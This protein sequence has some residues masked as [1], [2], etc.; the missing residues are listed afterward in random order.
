MKKYIAYLMCLVM[1]SA[2]FGCGKK[3]ASSDASKPDTTEAAT[4]ATASE[5]TDN[6]IMNA[7]FSD[8]TVGKW[9]TYTNGGSAVL[10][11]KAGELAVHITDP[12]S[13][14]YAVQAYYDGFAL[15]TGCDYSFS[16]D[17]HSD[18]ERV[19]EWR[20][21]INGSDYHAYTSD[22]MEIKNDVTRVEATFSMTEASDPAPRLCLNLGMFDDGPADLGDHTVFFDNFDLHLVDDSNK[23]V[24]DDAVETPDINLNQIGYRTDDVKKAVVRGESLD[25]KAFKV[26]DAKSGDVKFEGKLTG[27][28]SNGSSKETVAIADFTDLKEAG[29]YK[30]VTDD[31]GESYEFAIGDKV[32]EDLLKDAVKWYYS[33]RCGC[34]LDKKVVGD[35]AHEACHTGDATIYGTNKK[36]KNMNGGWHDAGDYGRYVVAGAKAAYDLLLAY[37]NNPEAFGDDWDMPY[38]NNGVPDILDEVKY[39]L[40]WMLKMQTKDGGVYHKL[41]TAAFAETVMPEEVKEDLIL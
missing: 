6:M 14:D 5:D 32:Y 35:F 34:S 15:D 33:Q 17:V 39:E 19:G 30:V 31:F 25:G 18:V 20:I 1:V 24:A 29:N 11:N 23:V 22:K 3:D 16:F 40:D 37:E 8:G 28:M 2:F 27:E 36:V 4:E 13:L 12:G 10:S 7:D 26:V 9:N 21:Q 38:S 41:T